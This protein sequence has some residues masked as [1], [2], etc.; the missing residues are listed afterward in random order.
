VANKT[1]KATIIAAASPFIALGVVGR[2]LRQ[3]GQTLAVVR[4]GFPHPV[5]GFSAK[6]GF[7]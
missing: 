4:T 6:V 3:P 2:N 7:S 1:A 5:Q